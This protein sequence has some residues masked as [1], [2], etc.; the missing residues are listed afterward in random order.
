MRQNS[1]SLLV[2][3][4]LSLLLSCARTPQQLVSEKPVAPTVE[5]ASEKIR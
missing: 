1:K 2:L 3:L 5:L 4:A